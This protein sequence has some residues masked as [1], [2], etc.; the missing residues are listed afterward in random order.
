MRLGGFWEDRFARGEMG[1]RWLKRIVSS[2]RVFFLAVVDACGALSG[3]S[4][5]V[6]SWIVYTAP[7]AAQVPGGS[8]QVFLAQR[9]SGRSGS[10]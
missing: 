3:R 9:P 6:F 1:S 7:D 4:W 10:R 5:L 8:E 2:I